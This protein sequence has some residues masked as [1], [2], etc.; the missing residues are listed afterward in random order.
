MVSAGNAKILSALREAQRR[1]DVVAKRVVALS[2]D[3]ILIVATL[4]D[5]LEWAMRHEAV[6]REQA[7]SR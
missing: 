3:D 5:E 1:L 2:N 6:L 7:A 4:G